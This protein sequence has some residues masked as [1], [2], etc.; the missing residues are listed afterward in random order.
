M[1]PTGDTLQYV[2][3]TQLGEIISTYGI[4]EFPKEIHKKIMLLHLFKKQL[5]NNEIV[6]LPV[7]TPFCHLKKWINTP[8]A[9]IFRL[10]NKVIQV[11]FKDSTELLL[12]SEK[13]HVT[14][15]DK[16]KETHSYSLVTAMESGDKQMIKRLKY[17]KEVLTNMLKARG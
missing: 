4:S 15:V 1:N 10:T 11:F 8:H 14:F 6:D 13:K 16:H 9:I 2:S 17:S 5:F 3:F 12:C 7:N